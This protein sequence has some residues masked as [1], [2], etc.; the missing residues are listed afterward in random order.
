MK[1]VF[2]FSCKNCDWLEVHRDMSR[3]SEVTQK[4]DGYCPKCGNK[5]V[6]YVEFENQLWRF[7]D[8]AGGWILAK[9]QNILMS[10][11]EMVVT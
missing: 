6:T 8:K 4:Y 9:D 2:C 7:D 5:T 11:K 3:L 10:L 1:R